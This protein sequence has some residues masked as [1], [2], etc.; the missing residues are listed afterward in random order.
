MSAID[1]ATSLRGLKFDEERLIDVHVRARMRFFLCSDAE[2]NEGIMP[3]YFP[4]G[5]VPP[6]LPGGAER[7]AWVTLLQDISVDVDGIIASYLAP[8][9]H[10]NNYLEWLAQDI[11]WEEKKYDSAPDTPHPSN[12]L[13][14]ASAAAYGASTLVALKSALDRLILVLHYFYSGIARHTTW[15]HC[16]EK[17]KWSGFMALVERS[18]QQDALLASISEA[19]TRWIRGAVGP[20]DALIHYRDA[21]SVWHYI[22]DHQAL[23]QTSVIVGPDGREHN[24]GADTLTFYVSEWYRLFESILLGLALRLPRPPRR[25]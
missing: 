13:R 24:F 16:N 20:R 21:D 15:G 1:V 22:S 12:I 7:A 14:R 9:L 19:Y 8:A 10:C 18:K 25:G 17:G 5:A 4:A 23:M 3:L 6:E 11:E 2:R